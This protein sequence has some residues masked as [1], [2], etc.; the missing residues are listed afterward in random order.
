[1]NP[2][3]LKVPKTFY[4]GRGC[5]ACN[6]TGYFDRIGIFE[7]LNITEEVRKL[8]ISPDFN[9][10]NLVKLGRS[11]GMTMMFEDGLKKVERGLTTIEELFRVI[12]E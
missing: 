11:Q 7:V 1:M 6:H 8:I 2:A 4:R 3:N 9:L 12:R 10:D 5:A